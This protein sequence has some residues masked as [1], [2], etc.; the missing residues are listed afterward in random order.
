MKTGSEP[1]NFHIKRDTSP[2]SSRVV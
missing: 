2:L 1:P